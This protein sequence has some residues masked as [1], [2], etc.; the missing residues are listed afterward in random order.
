MPIQSLPKN[1]S[2]ENLRNQHLEMA[3]LLIGL[4]A[5]P[6]IRDIEFNARPLG[7]AEYGK[8][9]EVAEF[10]RQFEPE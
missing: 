9:T 1:P 10:L 8:Q 3:K 6:L 4:G 5:D 2:L 7:W